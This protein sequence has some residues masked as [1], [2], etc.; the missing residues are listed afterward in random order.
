[1]QVVPSTLFNVQE[2]KRVTH[3]YSSV[4]RG[5]W[6]LDFKLAFRE[7]Y[8][9]AKW[10]RIDGS[11]AL[12]FPPVYLRV[13][14]VDYMPMGVT[15]ILARKAVVRFTANI[16]NLMKEFQ[17]ASEAIRKLGRVMISGQ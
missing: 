7:D 11:V 9:S 17:K 4:H 3:V 15:F 6:F 12:E 16:N 8:D 10:V 1:M 2:G 5:K 13:D 14:I